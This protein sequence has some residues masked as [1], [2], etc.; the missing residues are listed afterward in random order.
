VCES[1]DQVGKICSQCEW[2]TSNHMKGSNVTKRPR[3]DL[4]SLLESEHT[5]F[6][7]L[8]NQISRFSGFWIKDSQS[9]GL[10]VYHQFP[11]F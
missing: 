9:F 3:K 7:V 1:L 2:V 11:W 10:K 8:G 4:L 6:A 5:F